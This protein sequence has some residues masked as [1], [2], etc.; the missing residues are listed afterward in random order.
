MKAETEPLDMKEPAQPAPEGEKRP[1]LWY[2]VVL[3]TLFWVAQVVVGSLEKP[4]FV[5]FLYAM[6]APALLLLL[7]S[8]WWWTN[9]RIRLADRIYG[10][11]AV[12]A[13]GLAVAP[14]CH[15]SILFAVPT[16]GLPIALT[17][18][19]GWMVLERGTGT[20]FATRPLLRRLG[21]LGVLALCWGYFPLIRLEG[22]NAD[23]Q[24]D[25]RWR[26]SPTEE[27]IFLAERQ[28]STAGPSTPI[29]GSLPLVLRPGD[30]PAFRGEERE[31]IIR[32]VTLAANW[33]TAPP[34]LLWRQRVGPAWS[35]VIVIGDRLFTQEQRG[36]EET[37]V[38]NDAAT[39]RELWT[40]ADHCRF[41]EA[42]SGAGPRATPTF[43]GSYLF[44]LG[45]TGILN[46]LDAATGAPLWSHDIAADAPAKPPMWGYAGSPLVVDDLVIVFAGG[47]GSRNLLAYRTASGEPA[48]AAP[49]SHDGYASPQL[50]TLDGQRQCLLL[51][52]QGLTAVDPATGAFLWRF[53]WAQP[54]APRTL[55]AH[56]I[57]STRLLVGTLTGPGAAVVHVTH[58]SDGWQPAEVWSTS[59]VKPEFPDFVVHEG[60]A[61]GFDGALF[62]CIDLTS[63]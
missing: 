28:K 32:G 30:W 3:V 15:R 21:L 40:H 8:I 44:T 52:D 27:E 38:C 10:C 63:G 57:G 4:Y 12:V 17:A 6:A 1:R 39:G 19:T 5:G 55:Q 62:C 37:V 47:E 43:A 26:W 25:M 50:L 59:Q 20:F 51:G 13:L 58:Q 49:T 14:F 2:P 23:L 34:K 60:H 31:G 29:P 46:C 18:L 7:F 45:G 33:K 24:A 36:E 54:G 35:S 42:V 56:R 48:W 53:G 22:I 9:R 11:L 16:T 61:Y 41:W